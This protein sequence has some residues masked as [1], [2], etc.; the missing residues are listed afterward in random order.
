M[1][2]KTKRR[3]ETS[4]SAIFALS[5]VLVAFVLMFSGGSATARQIATL[6]ILDGQVEVRHDGESA[7]TARD[8]ESL[9]EGDVVETLL[10]G[11]AAIEYFD[12]SVTRL[13]F[14][15]TL[16]LRSLESP[17]P[18]AGPK[19]IEISQREGNTYNRVVESTDPASRFAIQTPTATA[20]VDGTVYAVMVNDDGSTTIATLEGLVTASATSG[21]VDVPAGKM[22]IVDTRGS[23]GALLDIPDTLLNSDWLTFNRCAVERL[24]ACLPPDRAAPEGSEDESGGG[25]PGP[26]SVPPDEPVEGPSADDGA[27]PPGRNQQPDAEFTAS[28]RF[29]PAPLRV[30]FIDT[31]ADPDGDSLSRMWY[32]GDGTSQNGGST[33]MHVYDRQGHYAVTLVVTDP[34]GASDTRTRVIS[35]GA[36]ADHRAPRV[37]ITSR[38]EN[39]TYAR[40]ARFR[41]RSSEPGTGFIC[42][43]DGDRQPC[44]PAIP[45]RIG[46]D[47][48][49]SVDYTNLATG[50][51]SFTVWMTDASGNTGS[52]SFSWTI[53]ARARFDHIVI[54][55]SSAPIDLGDAQNYTAEAFDRNGDSLGNVTADTNFSIRPSGSCSGNTCTPTSA[56]TH[57]VVGKYHG[58]TDTATLIVSASSRCPNY[59]LSFHRRPPSVIDA[60]HRFN[61]QIRVEV[62]SGGD[63]DGPLAIS[64]SGAPFS[65]G[66]T[67]EIWSGNGTVVF[68]ALRVDQPG[69]YEVIATAHCT[70]P[71]DPAAVRVTEHRGGGAAMDAGL[72]PV[73]PALEAIRRRLRSRR[74]P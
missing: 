43:L 52:D 69:S 22:V 36:R 74:A 6:K 24:D 64:L 29:G 41:F 32:F 65:S 28:P 44:G 15:T 56:G 39:P 38:P 54:S 47:V 10:D 30:D 51:H 66:E 42:T 63:P 8:G 46:N 33:P 5:L 50:R 57:T 3:V 71:P 23:V 61:V 11:R 20:S 58:D 13:D 2:D 48:T 17:D 21:V 4:L 49:S 45:V 67:S 34:S 37:R 60:G 73:L 55:P 1:S 9:R 35:V 40:D 31:S 62:L 59:A 68:N 7:R 12:G 19:L 70:R 16:E 25:S 18:E 27:R 14:D 53:L 26:R 72:M